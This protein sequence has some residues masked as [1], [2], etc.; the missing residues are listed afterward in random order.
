M[1]YPQLKT[2]CYECPWCARA[3]VIKHKFVTHVSQHEDFDSSKFN[4]KS[5]LARGLTPFRELALCRTCGYTAH[6][7]RIVEKH[8]V[9]H[10]P[11]VPALFCVRAPPKKPTFPNADPER[12]EALEKQD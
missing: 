11:P 12:L 9:S 1:E 5:C 3:E 6:T 10:A 8:K 4:V 7:G 2:V